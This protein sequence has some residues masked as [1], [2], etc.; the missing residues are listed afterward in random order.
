MKYSEL[1]KLN[2]NLGGV[3][4]G[5]EYKISIISNIMLHQSKDICEYL[6][7]IESINAIVS[8]GEYD[9]IVQDSAKVQDE[10]VVLIFW[11][12][13]NFI[14]GLQYK[15][16]GLSDMEYR[17][18]I[19]KIKTEVDL[20]FKNLNNIPLVL[21]NKFSSIIFDRYGLLENRMNLLVKELNMYLESVAGTNVKI[22]DVDKVISRLSI[23]SS[24]DL[25]YYYLSKTLYSIDFYMQYF[26]YIKPIF[27]STVGRIK[28]ALIFDCDN[29]LWKG[30]LGEDGFNGIKVYQEVQYLAL[31]LL[32]QGVII[33]L[34]SKN[35]PMDVDEVLENHP[36]M[37]LQNDDIV[38]KK[39]NWDNKVT[40]LRSIAKDLNIGV[41]SLVF[42]DDSKFEIGLI[43]KELPDISCF[44]VP[45]SE[46]KY[47]LMMR[48]LT[49]LF[50]NTS[51]TK[52]DIKKVQLYKDQLLRSSSI[53]PANIDSY[54]ESLGMVL[55]VHIDN[56]EQ[57][58][59]IAQMTQ[60]TNQFN[61]TTKR[62]TEN[63]IKHLIENKHTSVI[64]ISVSDRYGDNGVTG[65]AILNNKESMIDMLLLSCRV[66]GR[67]IEYKFMDIIVNLAKNSNI[68]QLKSQ[69]I[70]TSK[71]QQVLSFYEQCGFI[72]NYSINNISDYILN[73]KDYKIQGKNYIKV[74]NGK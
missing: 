2:N 27:L 52:E 70:K 3:V 48:R 64:S 55:T 14:D 9:N 1:I 22:I 12:V 6:L 42:I 39:V 5:P 69:Y 68:K 43:K 73:I 46:Y 17:A 13:Y 63:D 50:Y 40:N 19:D 41:D 74:R 8:L 51:Q 72:K 10:N 25:R 30:I 59:R 11:E 28:K 60:K 21:I 34:C 54:L 36:D 35:N 26:E 58:L 33:G 31:S 61:L 62:H 44:Q 16:D 20:V 53:K 4:R 65:L 38:I 67:N 18:L 7:R 15:I 45:S 57:M 32:K 71:N 37:I 24:I 29:T 66:L 49:N 23:E 56:S 47:G